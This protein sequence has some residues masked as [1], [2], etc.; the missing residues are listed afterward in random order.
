MK[1]T[2]T[3]LEIGRWPTSSSSTGPWSNLVPDESSISGTT[4]SRSASRRN[5]WLVEKKA[6]AAKYHQLVNITEMDIQRNLT[7]RL[8]AISIQPGG[9]IILYMKASLSMA[10]PLTIINRH[11]QSI[12]MIQQYQPYGTLIVTISIHHW[13]L[14]SVANHYKPTLQT[15]IHHYQWPPNRH[16]YRFLYLGGQNT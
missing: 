5:L 11:Q 4:R 13:T 10:I 1:T 12:F 2:C 14:L 7:S 6:V 3:L 16:F 8:K 15:I 9:A